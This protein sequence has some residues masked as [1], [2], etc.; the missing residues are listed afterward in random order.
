M[1]AIVSEGWEL[2]PILQSLAAV[3]G[4]AVVTLTVAF[5]AL[6]GRTSVR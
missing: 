1:R 6:R 4:V 5:A 2:T 3:V